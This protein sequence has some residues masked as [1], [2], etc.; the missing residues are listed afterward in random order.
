LANVYSIRKKILVSR[1]AK[2]RL[3]ASAILEVCRDNT[4]NPLYRE[5][6]GRRRKG[7]SKEMREGKIEGWDRR[8][9]YREGRDGVPLSQILD[10]SLTVHRTPDR[11]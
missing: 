11:G 5:Q 8:E 7:N 4:P 3:F 1:M 6:E 9:R 10:T 2:S